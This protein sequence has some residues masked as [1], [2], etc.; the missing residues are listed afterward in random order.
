[1][2]F[3][4]TMSRKQLHRLEVIQHI[5]DRRRLGGL[6]QSHRFAPL[7]SIFSASQILISD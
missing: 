4:I 6:E 3:M 5:R 7:V 2:S 1:M